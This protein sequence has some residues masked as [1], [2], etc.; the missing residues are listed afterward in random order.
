MGTQQSMVLTSLK[1]KYVNLT[2]SATTTPDSPPGSM[3]HA[4]H[5]KQSSAVKEDQ[6]DDPK[7]VLWSRDKVT[8]GWRKTFPPG[9][10]MV[11]LGNT[12]YMNSSLQVRGMW[13]ESVEECVS[14]MKVCGY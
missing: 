5:H 3:A 12:C 13:N 9:A 7:F 8:L 2:A 10:G 6:L 4:Q 11:N 14:A 1:T